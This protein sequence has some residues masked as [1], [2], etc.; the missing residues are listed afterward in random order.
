MFAIFPG[1]C[2][3]KHIVHCL[4]DKTMTTLNRRGFLWTGLGFFASTTLANAFDFR[5]FTLKSFV[6]GPGDITGTVIKNDAPGKPWK[7]SREAFS[8]TPLPRGKVQCDICPNRCILAEGDRSICR[9][10]VN[11][12][13]VLYTLTYGNPC[14]AHVDPIEK[15]PLFHFRPRTLAYS[16]A[17]AG[18]NF[19]CL[20]CQ[21]W[22]ISQA[23][24]HEVRHTELFPADVVQAALQSEAASIAYTY[25]EATSFF[26]Y[27]LDTARLARKKNISNLYISNGYINP[28]PLGELVKVIDAANINLKAFS[29]AIYKKLN[30]G[31]LAPV[32]E[33]LKHLHRAKVHLEI[34]NLVVPGYTDDPEMV[35]RMCGWI[36]K[37]LGP[38]HPLHFLRFF[39]TYKLDR[40]SPTPVSTLASFREIALGE[41]IRYVY[42]G[43]VPEH[44]GN[45]TY[46]HQCRKKIVHRDGYNLDEYHIK[47]GAC[48]FCGTKIPGV[49]DH[50]R[51]VL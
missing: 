26:E 36:V 29:D 11:H 10:K 8:Y 42:V 7:W 19:R 3:I 24:P 18:C 4:K 44:E 41:G 1:L 17:A 14:A 39:P 22:E 6:S 48:G 30:G 37:N 51:A 28:G 31:R 46:C 12:N 50:G 34:T 40:L 13:G 45:H 23:R 32:L 49:W 47:N 15:K 9:S 20:N 35:K 21:N 33:T 16:I 25:S 38:D 43:N 2:H 5:S 27:M